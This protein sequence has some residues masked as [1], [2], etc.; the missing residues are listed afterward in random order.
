MD[1]GNRLATSFGSRLLWIAPDVVG[2]QEG[3]LAL[4]GQWKHEVVALL[5]LGVR[6]MVVAQKGSL[7]QAAFD[8]KVEELLGR[9]DYVRGVPCAKGAT[10]VEEIEAFAAARRP[11]WM[12]LLGMGL[13]AMKDK[14]RLVAEAVARANPGSQL[15]YDSCLITNSVASVGRDSH[16]RETRSGGCI[17]YWA[18]TTARKLWGFVEGD[19]SDPAR[20]IAYYRAAIRLAWGDQDVEAIEAELGLAR[21][22]A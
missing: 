6:V 7:S 8:A 22:A 14:A 2:S 4:L 17:L 1:L 12:H 13:W 5:E 9:G 15:S 18:K 16:P 19:R 20:T 21:V 3:T 10:S 11:R